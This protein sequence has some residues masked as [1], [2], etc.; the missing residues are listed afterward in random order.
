MRLR[1]AL[2]FGSFNP[3]HLGHLMLAQY[4]LNFGGVDD[5]WLVVSPQNPFKAQ[6]GL[7]PAERRL[8]MARKAVENDDHIAVC[9]VELGMPVPSYTIKTLDKLATDYP[10]REFVVVMGGDNLAGLPKWREA[11][12][13]VREHRVIVYPR[14]GATTDTSAVEAM[15][16]TVTLLD[17]PQLNLSSTQIRQWVADGH[18][19]AHFVPREVLKDV[20]ETYGGETERQEIRQ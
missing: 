16:G 4:V 5:V 15:G 11:E 9:D 13:L 8:L 18:S 1:T 6:A 17:A 14:P 12:R 20:R 7:A 3:V 19:V 2:L 10:D